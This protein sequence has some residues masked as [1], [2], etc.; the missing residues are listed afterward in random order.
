MTI[1]AL[2]TWQFPKDF[3]AGIEAAGQ[4]D[5]ENRLARVLKA[6]I[7]ELESVPFS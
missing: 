6:A 5:P 3:V 1:R 4:R 2:R 7:S